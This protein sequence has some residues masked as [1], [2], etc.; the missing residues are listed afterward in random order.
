M[1][2]RAKDALWLPDVDRLLLVKLATWHRQDGALD[3]KRRQFSITRSRPDFACFGYVT[4]VTKVT[5]GIG[6]ASGILADVIASA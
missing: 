6:N 1:E 5:Y 4:R 3:G 2:I